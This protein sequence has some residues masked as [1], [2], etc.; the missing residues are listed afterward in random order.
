[1]NA[2]RAETRPRHFDGTVLVGLLLAALGL[3]VLGGIGLYLASRLEQERAA[4]RERAIASVHEQRLALGDR[5]QGVQHMLGQL[6]ARLNETATREAG[7][8]A[9]VQE[10]LRAFESVVPDTR[11]L[12]LV[13]DDGSVVSAGNVLGGRQTLQ[14]WCPWLATRR[15]RI[16]ASAMTR[17]D[18][19]APSARCPGPGT[20]V[21]PWRPPSLAALQRATIWL[22]LDGERFGRELQD[23]LPRRLPMARWR[24]V[25][26]EGLTL[27][28]GQHGAPGPVDFIAALDRP[29]PAAPRAEP[30][31]ADSDAHEVLTWQDANGLGRLVAVSEAV[32]ETGLRVQVMLPEYPAIADAWHRT[33]G[34]WGTA[35][36]VFLLAWAAI[37]TAMLRTLRRADRTLRSQRERFDL[38]LDHAEVGVWEW[39]VPGG[40]VAGSRQMERLLGSRAAGGVRPLVAL[41]PREDRAPLVRRL[42]DLIAHGDHLVFEQR[43]TQADGR[44]RWLVCS[45]HVQRDAQGRALRVLGV[46]RDDTERI[47]AARRIS[48]LASHTA[49]ILDNVV[50]AIIS[51]DEH[52][53]I[54]AFNAA[55]TRMFGHRAEQAVGQ[56]V[57][58]LMPAPWRD[59]HDGHV[60]RYSQSGQRRVIGAGREVLGLHRDGREF[61]IHLAVSEYRRDGRRMFV[62]LIRDVTEQRRAEA[63]IRSLAFFDQLTGLP[64]RRLLLDRVRQRVLAAERRHEQ[65]ALL[66]LDLDDFKTLNDSR[67]HEAG[68]QLLRELAGRLRDA[69]R[70][71]DTVARLGGDEFVIL[72]DN[73]GEDRGDA[74][75]HAELVVHKLMGLFKTPFTPGGV[76]HPCRASIGVTLFDGVSLADGRED[77]DGRLRADV[78]LGQADMAMYEV[79]KT[80]RDGWRF[81]DRQLQEHL[82]RR[83]ALHHDLQHALS[84]GEFELHHQPQVDQAGDVTGVEALLR[85]RHP[86][87][88]MVPPGEFITEA[89]SNGLI[90][91]IGRQVLRDACRLLARWRRDPA[92]AHL[93]VAVNV[94]VKQFHHPDFVE[95]VM[96]ALAEAG[97]PAD[98]LELELTESAFADDPALVRRRMETLRDRGLRF[99]LDDFGIGYSSLAYLKQLPLDRLKIDQSFVR[100]LLTDP[101][102]ASIVQA[103]V[104]MGQ[105]LRLQV[106]AEGVEVEAQR[107]R[108][109][110]IGCRDYQ[111]WL[112][113]R[114]MPEALLERWLDERAEAALAAPAD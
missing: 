36:A 114:P 40:T 59:E 92:R 33:L 22:L 63:E 93:T 29:A 41:L 75:L 102:D 71:D 43:L 107:R 13:R 100:D 82:D 54:D 95:D 69:V 47:E 49:A 98:R 12:L 28:A 24:V 18:D 20:V 66:L 9:A 42:R 73:L 76:P 50:D 64:N 38:A 26:A 19:H 52:G 79:K 96:A 85:W 1:M 60:H 17:L 30:D 86:K 51:I 45:A 108:L 61:P 83:V 70:Q 44:R 72:L 32:G 88:G 31:A 65:G 39:D 37:G 46:L 105:S 21:I 77:P 5:L 97:A 101:N 15:A 84:H 89:E 48:E 4:V 55:A 68:D 103:I 91:D 67:G 11:E 111:G 109:S 78:L 23:S 106:I 104:T 27:A 56:P 10:L 94:S 74:A 90:I 14:T 53:R 6:T 58:M 3:L 62:G 80:G 57:T 16:E 35:A 99:S 112:F 7:D 34:L 113:A 2:S 87:R 110:E 81:F 25:D 8:E